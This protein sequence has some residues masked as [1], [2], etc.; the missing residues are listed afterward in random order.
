MNLT[1]GFVEPSYAGLARRAECTYAYTV[2]SAACGLLHRFMAFFDA[3]CIVIINL[4]KQTLSKSGLALL[5][6]LQSCSA[7]HDP[8][9][10]LAYTQPSCIFEKYSNLFIGFTGLAL[11][12]A[13]ISIYILARIVHAEYNELKKSKNCTHSNTTHKL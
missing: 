3:L 7:T 10:S 9:P 1:L 6:F 5:F 8:G 2:Y 13:L 12:W 4:R 11:I